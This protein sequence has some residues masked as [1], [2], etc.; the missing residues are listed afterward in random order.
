MFCHGGEDSS[1]GVL[2]VVPPALVFSVWRSHRTE[3][4]SLLQHHIMFVITEVVRKILLSTFVG[5]RG[6]EPP[7]SWSR[8]KRSNR[9]EPH[10]EQITFLLISM[11]RGRDLNPRYTLTAYGGLAN[12]WFKPLTHLSEINRLIFSYFDTL[13]CL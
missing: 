4:H 10:P 9:A 12:R 8:T 3:S 2:S 6:F 7:T 11:R 1:E 13:F 5:V